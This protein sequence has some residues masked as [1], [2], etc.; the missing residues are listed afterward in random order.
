MLNK[1]ILKCRIPLYNKNKELID[2]TYV[3]PNDFK[4][5]NKYKWYL[6][7]DGYVQ[8]YNNNKYWFLHRYILINIHNIVPLTVKHKFIDHINNNKLDNTFNNLRFVTP[9]ENTC[10]S[11][12]KKNATSKYHGVSKS[13]KDTKWK[14]AIKIPNIIIIHAYY[15][16]EVHA[17]WQYNLW[18]KEYKLENLKKLN[19]IIKCPD[20]FI[21]YEIKKK[22]NSVL[23]NIKKIK[24][25]YQ[26]CIYIH[27]YKK[28]VE[29]VD[30]INKAKLYKD[31]IL[32]Y[33][34]NKKLL[35]VELRIKIKQTNNNNDIIIIT[36]KNEE[37]IIDES[38]YNN[39]IKYNWY[40]N[41]IGY[42]IGRI[43]NKL[44]R[45]GRYIL[46]YT[47]NNF[48]DHI[49]NNK[50]D[51]RKCNL[52]IVTP[53]QNA[54]N[55]IS[56]KN[57]TS[58]YIGVSKKNK[59]YSVNITVNGKQINLGKFKNEMDAA[60]CRDDGTKLYYGEYGNLNFKD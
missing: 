42:T 12:K 8:G 17:A 36:K 13:K 16:N 5:V 10:N 46:N 47:G 48:V 52:R 28:Y 25:K 50:L 6:S 41:D 11:S 55:K 29:T 54:M 22:E 4:I 35:L 26:I 56:A 31:M 20:N 58:N 39:L 49:N 1:L 14:V 19:N 59:Y 9:L 53:A 3:S 7:K 40:L 2:Y 45:M 24:D 37:I 23:K 21:I 34:D 27:K 15:V 43:N 18:I 32:F 30:N 44:Y 60:K 38:D 33:K 51:N 57:S